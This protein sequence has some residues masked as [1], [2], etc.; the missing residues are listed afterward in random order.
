MSEW[1]WVLVTEGGVT[2]YP[3]VGPQAAYA[4]AGVDVDSNNMMGDRPYFLEFRQF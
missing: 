1:A 3:G 4:A 2:V